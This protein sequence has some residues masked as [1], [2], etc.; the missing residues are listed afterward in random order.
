[1]LA[2]MALGTPAIAKT[3]T[4]ISELAR[5][6]IEKNELTFE[7]NY[8]SP[9]GLPSYPSSDGYTLTLSDGVVN[10]YLPFVGQ[11]SQAAFGS[12]EVGF[13]F[14]DCPVKV[15]TRKGKKSSTLK[16]SARSGNDNVD[17]TIEIWP[18]GG[19]EVVFVSTYRSV[20]RYSGELK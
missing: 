16:F 17:V 18:D 1:M 12:D 2:A 11:S 6:A 19:A 20:M 14:K 13:N 3:E 10:A 4:E 15:K 5:K 7:V 8:I 9:M